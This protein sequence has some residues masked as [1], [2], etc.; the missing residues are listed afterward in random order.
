M[1][2][3]TFGATAAVV[4]VVF[5]M[6][7]MAG[8]GV[9]GAAD[10]VVDGQP[11]AVLV[12]PTEAHADEQLA[13]Q[14]IV[15]HVRL[16]SG[17]ELTVAHVEQPA[18]TKIFIGLSLFSE[19][20]ARIRREGDDPAAFLL[21]V[22][23]G[24]VH[25]A[26]L[27]PEGTLFAAYELLEQLGVRWCMPGELGRV[28]PEKRTVRLAEQETVQVPSF[29]SRL[30]QTI[31]DR[32][33]SRRMRL[34]GQNA[35]AHNLPLRVNREE[36]P[37]L[38]YEE[39]GRLTHQHR[40]SH[41]EVQR[42][43][44]EATLD[45]FRRNPDAPYMNMGPEDGPGFGSDP[46]DADDMDPLHG[47]VSVTD[48]Y[49][50]FFN[51]VLDTVQKEF[52]GKG[53]AF[54]CYS[55]HMRP[56]VREK[57]NPAILPVLAP[58]DLC[59]FHSIDNPLCPERA[60]MKQIIDGWQALGCAMFYRGYFFNLADQG[61]PFSMIRQI[62]AEIPYFKQAGLIGCRVECMPMWGYHA[63]SLYL[64]AR[65]FWNA[66]ADSRAIMDDYFEK[67]Y[68]PARAAMQ[69]HFNTLEDAFEQADYHTG[70]VFDMPHILNQAVMRDL[71][72]SL[73][74][75]ERRAGRQS[76]YAERVA[77]VRLSYDYG[78]AN[79]EMMAALNAFRFEAAKAAHD[80]AVDL[81][82]KGIA[83][84]P[85]LFWPP[86]S[87][88]Y[89][90]RFWTRTVE[91]AVERVKNGNEIVACLPDEWLFILD[92][93]D[94][95]EALGF[96]KPGMGTNMWTRIKTFSQSWSNQGLRYYKGEAW[97]RT[98]VEV[99]R[100]FTGRP[101]RLWLGGVDD[102]AKAW[103]NGVPLE[104]MSRGAAPSGIPWEFDASRAVRFGQPNVIVVKV[105]NR[106]IDELGTGGLTGPAMLWAAPAE[107]VGQPQVPDGEKWVEPEIR[108]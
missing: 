71:D 94:G 43:T 40:V 21:S 95:G 24:E 75:A 13:A 105:S 58:I 11:R 39:G 19:A 81:Q 29:A 77:L 86:A 97:Y 2:K 57:L 17:A 88:N 69:K 102:S 51:L 36:R 100:R 1:A 28:I 90:R 42:L 56:P 5:L 101:I 108:R 74:D 54:Y 38:Y 55:Q 48:R 84:D 49:I 80:R 32:Q 47:K 9:A 10:L 93:L 20:T 59:R 25:L 103:L 31:A 34:G 6:M 37:E 76:P 62:S 53:I 41:P 23:K 45:F 107:S 83:M 35:G 7:Q 46:W 22:K 16:M 91:S 15:E 99:H 3:K 52:P 85:P 8:D 73:R 65:L 61:L 79:L 78:A 14:E 18:D 92:P 44:I 27:S 4:S 67:F 87:R 50:K 89:L 30:L 60:Y 12:L 106:Q 33:W 70:N 64:A 72:R 104:V 66:E 82:E 26:G 96:W 63:P 98:T 68:G